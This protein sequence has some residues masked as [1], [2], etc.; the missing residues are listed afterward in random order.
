[1][2][3]RDHLYT[4]DLMQHFK[5]KGERPEYIRLAISSNTKNVTK[6]NIDSLVDNVMQTQRVKDHLENSGTIRIKQRT[7]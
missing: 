6:R 4:N 5:G 1:M 2:D 3:Y 7:H